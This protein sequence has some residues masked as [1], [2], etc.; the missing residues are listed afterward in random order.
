[1]GEIPP[2]LEGFEGFWNERRKLLSDAMAK[3]LNEHADAGTE[4]VQ[5]AMR[6]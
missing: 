2:D 6:A 4:N 5:E 1:L 3:I